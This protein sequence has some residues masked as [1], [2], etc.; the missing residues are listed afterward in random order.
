[1]PMLFMMLAAQANAQNFV[2]MGRLFTT[3]GERAQLD[4]LRGQ[5]SQAAANAAAVGGQGANPGMVVGCLPGAAAPG[6]P[7]QTAP[8]AEAPGTA[9]G[10]DAAGLR[11]DGLIRRGNGSAVLILNGE[12][13][14]APPSAV[15]RGAVRLQADGHAV[16]L[17][18]GQR[19]DSASGEI[20]EPDR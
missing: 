18:P 13:Q 19:Y 1:M 5:A 17:K 9:D 8:A 12:V 2:S 4:A 10:P 7:P 3:P 6:C 20:H 11:L 14:A 15:L 16:V